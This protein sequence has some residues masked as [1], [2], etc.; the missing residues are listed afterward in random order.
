MAER[1]PKNRINKCPYLIS[2]D[3]VEE[4]GA[5]RECIHSDA[6]VTY[7]PRECP[8]GIQI[9]QQRERMENLENLL[10]R[11]ITY[12]KSSFLNEPYGDNARK[13]YEGIQ[14]ALKELEEK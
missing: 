4:T 6:G 5:D 14:A 3:D 8:L 11:A 12:V 7:F 13:T 10:K 1:C 9:Q 2:I